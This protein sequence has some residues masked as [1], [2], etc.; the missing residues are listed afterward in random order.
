MK[1]EKIRELSDEELKTRGRNRMKMSSACDFSWRRDRPKGSASFG[2]CG[3]TLLESRPL[4]R[5]VS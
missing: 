5:N 2:L 1:A 4:V 3:R